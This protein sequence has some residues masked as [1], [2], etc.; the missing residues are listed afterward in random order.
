[1]ETNNENNDKN[2]GDKSEKKDEI[3]L[4]EII[5]KIKEKKHEKYGTGKGAIYS[6]MGRR[7]LV[8]IALE[9]DAKIIEIK[10]EMDDLRFEVFKL[11]HEL[12]RHEPEKYAAPDY[13]GYQ[14]EWST[15]RKVVFILKRNFMALTSSQ[16]LKE[17]L[18]IEPNYGLLWNDPANSVSR[19]L[20]RACKNK[21]V[22]RDDAPF[23]GSPLYKIPKNR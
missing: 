22:V 14:V 17:L 2:A 23:M 13:L 8:D 15:I 20:S 21:L 18:R 11:K 10:K 5:K 3:N 16:V 19:I 1:M 4:D 12:K 6:G 7:A 9:R